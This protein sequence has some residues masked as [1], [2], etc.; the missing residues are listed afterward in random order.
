[1]ATPI[2]LLCSNVEKFVR[3]EIG[4]TCVIRVTKK[5]KF[6]LPLYCRYCS[7]R[8]QNLSG[9]A[10]ALGSHFQISS[11]SVHFRRSYSRT[12]QR[13]SFTPWNISNIRFQANNNNNNSSS[14]GNNSYNVLYW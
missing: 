13:R 2:D 7:D 12:R 4:E 9:P 5:T 3:R 10:P 14:P 11:K 1:M 8:A 6:R